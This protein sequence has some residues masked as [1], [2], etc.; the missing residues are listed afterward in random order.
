MILP[1]YRKRGADQPVLN[2]APQ[3]IV[4]AADVAHGREPTVERES[5]HAY[6]MRRPVQVASEIDL[7]AR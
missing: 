4:A 1:A 2:S 6:R 5:E 7:P 3:A